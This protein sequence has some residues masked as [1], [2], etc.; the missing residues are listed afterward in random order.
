MKPQIQSQA[1]L[2]LVKER[3]S[4]SLLLIDKLQMKPRKINLQL[5]ML[6]KL[7]F[8]KEK[9]SWV[10]FSQR[11]SSQLVLQLKNQT[12]PKIGEKRK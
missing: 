4:L 5:T 7:L 1:H 3:V 10:N 6:K 8:K 9:K 11:Q 12:W 2:Y